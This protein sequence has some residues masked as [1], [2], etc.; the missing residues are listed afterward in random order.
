MSD[1]LP[2]C[3]AYGVEKWAEVDECGP[4]NWLR[5]CGQRLTETRINME[6]PL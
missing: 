3:P 5:S 6:D 4:C 1:H 2:E